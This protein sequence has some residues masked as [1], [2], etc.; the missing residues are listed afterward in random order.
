MRSSTARSNSGAF[1]AP[2]AAFALLLSFVMGIWP[3]QETSNQ[4][5]VLN[6]F[7]GNAAYQFQSPD[8]RVS[9]W[10]QPSGPDVLLGGFVVADFSKLGRRSVSRIGPFNRIQ[11][12]ITD[13]RATSEF[14]NGLR[15]KGIEV[16]EI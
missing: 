14:T 12:L 6:R 15:K 10:A 7:Q 5:L 9:I 4:F 8:A 16:I 11:R 1:Q 3:Q 2:T 13:K